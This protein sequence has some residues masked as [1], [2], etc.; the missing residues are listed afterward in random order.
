[1][2]VTWS[3][4]DLGLKAIERELRRLAKT[5]VTAGVHGTGELGKDDKG[6]SVQVQQHLAGSPGSEPIDMP[7]LASIHEFGTDTIPER[8]FVRSGVDQGNKRIAKAYDKGVERICA[9]TGTA[10]NAGELLG[11]VAVG[12]IKMRIFDG[13]AP[14]LAPATK[15]RRDKSKLTGKRLKSG[16]AE[17]TGYTPLLDSGQLAG[18]IAYQVEGVR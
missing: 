5:T 15:K 3:D 9:G 12:A 10:K 17:Q 8:S 13:I 7:L 1:M 4:K 18:S 2:A 11:V 14:E 16:N 6:Q